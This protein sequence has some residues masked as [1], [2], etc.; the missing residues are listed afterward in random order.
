MNQF[1]VHQLDQS[2]LKSEFL[3]M[4]VCLFNIH[5]CILYVLCIVCIFTT[6]AVCSVACALCTMFAL[7]R[8]DCNKF[9]T[10]LRQT[11]SACCFISA[12][13]AFFCVCLC[14]CGQLFT[15]QS[16]K[17]EK[18]YF[19]WWPKEQKTNQSLSNQLT[20]YRFRDPKN[21]IQLFSV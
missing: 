12:S 21:T 20:F 7:T 18:E 2:K 15:P 8:I 9:Q 11:T 16:C 4:R 17:K 5:C 3:V 1:G 14:L 13:F 19:R 10:C 6:F